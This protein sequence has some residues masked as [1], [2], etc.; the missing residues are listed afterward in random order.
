ML[1]PRLD[2]R[3]GR[4]C[5][6]DDLFD[7]PV[8]D[9][10]PGDPVEVAIVGGGV[11]GAMLAERL[12]AD[13]RLVLVLDRR[14]PATGATAAS[15]ALVLWAPDTPL[16]EHV[17]RYGAAPAYRRWRAVFT[18]V[19]EL[20]ARLRARAIPFGWA[21]RP[22]LY[23]AGPR[24]DAEALRR[25]A[26]A[27]RTAGLPTEWLTGDQVAAAF[28]VRA[29]AALVSQG[30]FEANP[31]ALARGLL[32]A[33][34]RAGARAVFPAEVTSLEEADDH[35]SIRLADG[36][37][38]AARHVVLATGYETGAP[39]LAGF[40]LGS[41]FAIASPPDQPA[42]WRQRAMI[43]EAADPYLYLR[44]TGDGRIVV[45]GED[46]DLVAS[47]ARDAM[48][49]RK[50]QRLAELVRTRLDLPRFE[51]DCA[52]AATFGTSDDGLPAIGLRPGS[53]RTLLAQSFGGNGVAFAALAAGVIARWLGGQATP[54]DDD[55]RPDRFGAALPGAVT[56]AF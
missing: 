9:P 15:T 50:S 54:E 12:A 38:L 26:E 18:A 5:W 16:V 41:S 44:T 21:A 20:N 45:G 33:A 3:G 37:S 10:L 2:L 35:V 34:R 14:T 22:D 43:W 56:P 8:S 28:A 53:R 13:G 55:F 40:T 31:V 39:R 32:A 19:Q 1:T 23:L 11:T 48:I 30:A 25:E 47:T 49:P 51:I 52:W 27:R 4:E 17:A 7:M 42:A 24:L 6:R 29:E 36:R 46:E